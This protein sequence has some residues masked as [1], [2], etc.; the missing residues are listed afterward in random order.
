MIMSGGDLEDLEEKLE[1][2]RVPGV[3]EV[4]GTEK[5]VELAKVVSLGMLRE[6]STIDCMTAIARVKVNA[7]L[8]RQPR[9]NTD[10]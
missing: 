3:G 1:L 9:T 7:Q 6:R 8:M 2:K 10:K 4:G 5:D